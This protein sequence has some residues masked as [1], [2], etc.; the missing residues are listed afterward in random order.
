MRL[1]D[2]LLRGLLEAA[3]DASVAVDDAG[4][5][6]FA[7]RQT[8]DLFGWEEGTL[9]GAEVEALVP[10]R[11]GDRHPDLRASYASAPSSRPMGASTELWARR[12]DGSEFPVE[13]SLSAPRDW[14]LQRGFDK[15][16]TLVIESG[17]R[18]AVHA[19][20]HVGV[21]GP[22]SVV[23]TSGTDICR[24]PEDVSDKYPEL[25]L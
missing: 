20:S 12:R 8:L 11:F 23:L 6:V 9:V 3:P 24:S 18:V 2:E 1:S 19:E 17:K 25:K 13:I 14:L 15:Q 22:I 21:E 4:R 5:I 16:A 10:E 7:N